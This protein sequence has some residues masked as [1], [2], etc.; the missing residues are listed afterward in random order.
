MTHT[1]SKD[2]FFWG[3]EEDDDIADYVILKIS[4]VV[5]AM[6]N[7]VLNTLVI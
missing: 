2:T 6:S 4:V 1:K 5:I 3:H 7:I